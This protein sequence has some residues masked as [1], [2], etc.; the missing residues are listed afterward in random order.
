[1]RYLV[2][3]PHPDDMAF[4]FGGTVAQLIRQGHEVYTLVITD[5]QQG[6][7]NRSYKTESELAAV[8]RA[9][10][11]AACDVLGVS[12]IEFCGL[13]NHFL[14]PSFELRETILRH[15]RKIQ[16]ATVMTLDP[17]NF[18]ENP[19]HR[20]VGLATHE[21][22]SFAHMHLFHP[23]H[24]EQGLATAVVSKIVLGKTNR[25]NVCM[26]I[27]Q[28]ID[29]KI[30]AIL[31]YESQ[32]ELFASE[33]AARMDQN[34]KQNPFAD[35]PVEEVIPEFVRSQAAAIGAKQGFS[36]A[37]SFFITGLGIQNHIDQVVAE[38]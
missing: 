34:G 25:A 20:A 11:Q 10:Q 16:P 17:W 18:D 36:A 31:C 38:L 28:Q 14:Q 30:E 3:E 37:E 32:L 22:C 8:M 13:K 2:V 21:A 26:D 29:L 4:F 6:T 12:Q 35:R 19:D 1:M 9:E 33:G 7:M 5:G 15:I 27:S 23:E 24:L